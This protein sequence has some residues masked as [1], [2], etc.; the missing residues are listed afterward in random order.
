MIWYFLVNL[1]QNIFIKRF[2]IQPY[3]KYFYF[4]NLFS[5]C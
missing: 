5:F 1:F 3:K 2:L 4:R